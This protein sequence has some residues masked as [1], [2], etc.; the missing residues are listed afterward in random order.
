MDYEYV[1]KI[2]INLLNATVPAKRCENI[3]IK[4]YLTR[5]SPEMFENWNKI[6]KNME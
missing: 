2:I 1:K 3:K 5:I 4:I 6:S